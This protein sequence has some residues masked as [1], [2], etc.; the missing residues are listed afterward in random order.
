[1]PTAMTRT[2]TTERPASKSDPTTVD[3]HQTLISAPVGIFRTDPEGSCLFVNERWCQFAGMAASAA[4][5]SGWMVAIHPEDRERVMTEWQAAIDEGREFHLEY[6]FQR[7]DG[8]VVWLSGSAMPYPDAHGRV[9]GHVGTVMD[10]GDAVAARESLR[11][12][13]RFVDAVIDVAGSLFCVFDPEG[14]FLRFNRACEVLSGYTFDEIRGR[15]FYEFLIPDGEIEN[16]RAALA[17]LRA[18]DV[19][20]ILHPP[21]RTAGSPGTGLSASSPGRTS[22]ST[23]RTGRSPTSSARVSTSPTSGAPRS[24]STGSRRSEP[25]SPSRAPRRSRWG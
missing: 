7:P 15:P 12:E 16:V 1:M 4:L 11:D 3:D 20:V 5:G 13:S 21:T 19:V 23:T 6:R 17:R 25:F 22:R 8:S 9:G 14:R 24:L 10:I 2:R 18:G